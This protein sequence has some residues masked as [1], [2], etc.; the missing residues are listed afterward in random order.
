MEIQEIIRINNIVCRDESSEFVEELVNEKKYQGSM[1]DLPIEYRHFQG[2]FSNKLA[3][4][5]QPVHPKYFCEIRFKEGYALPKPSKPIP[6][7][8]PEKLAMEK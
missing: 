5:L 4:E 7:S 2:V 6:L 1:S 3:E 8:R